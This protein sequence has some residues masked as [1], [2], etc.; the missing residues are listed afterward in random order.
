MIALYEER[1]TADGQTYALG[2]SRLIEQ[3]EA[4]RRLFAELTR[5]KCEIARIVPGE[6]VIK[7]PLFVQTDTVSF[8]AEAWE[9]QLLTRGTAIFALMSECHLPATDPRMGILSNN[10]LDAVRSLHIP[11]RNRKIMAQ[12]SLCILFGVER[13]TSAYAHALQ[14]EIADHITTFQMAE[15]DSI[16]PTKALTILTC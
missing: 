7:V 8:S 2:R 12:H 6:V 14:M 9:L 11:F 13:Y 4:L 16:D 1:T 3:F 15:E 5:T 10:D